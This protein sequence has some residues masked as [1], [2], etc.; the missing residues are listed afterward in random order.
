MIFTPQTPAGA[1]QKLVSM[2]RGPYK[3]MKKMSPVTYRVEHQLVARMPSQ[4]VHRNRM[5]RYHPRHDGEAHQSEMRLAAEQERVRLQQP[6][7]A[8][9]MQVQKVVGKKMVRGRPHYRLR[10]VGYGPQADTWEPEEWLAALGA[11]IKEYEEA[12]K[13]VSRQA[14]YSRSQARPTT[15]GLSKTQRAFRVQLS[16]TP[17]TERRMR[18]GR[19][20]PRD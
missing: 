10:W 16:S 1:K 6:S 7:H 12:Q 20:N 11:E 5:K 8:L 18:D 3:V 15:G 19:D 9:G 4:V 13:N 14:R 2:W 17:P